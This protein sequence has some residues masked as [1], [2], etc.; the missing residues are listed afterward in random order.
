MEDEFV[1][2][3]ELIAKLTKLRYAHGNLPVFVDID[4]GCI[5]EPLQIDYVEHKA[6][7]VLCA[8]LGGS[9]PERVLIY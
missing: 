8:Y 4:S 7:E 5:E 2:L 1:R 6:A 9:L 3:D